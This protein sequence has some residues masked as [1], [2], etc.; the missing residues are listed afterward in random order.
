MKVG[1]RRVKKEVKFRFSFVILFFAASF[2]CWFALY[3]KENQPES[4]YKSGGEIIPAAAA[5]ETQYAGD[6]QKTMRYLKSCI[7]AGGINAE[8]MAEFGYISE[9]NLFCGG[10]LSVERVCEAVS[11]KYITA[12]YLMPDIS[13]ESRFDEEIKTYGDIT[14]AVQRDFPDINIYMTLLPPSA[15]IS[16]TE[17]S[18]SINV[19]L[20]SFSK[21][22]GLYCLDISSALKDKNGTLPDI[23]SSDEGMEREAYGTVTSYILSHTAG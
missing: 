15:D 14:A 4:Y 12:L 5:G 22:N 23:Y 6:R 11:E 9:D 20:T 2:L 17:V 8:K 21:E 19:L 7:F 16:E 18:D 3:M 10:D 1:R 13:S